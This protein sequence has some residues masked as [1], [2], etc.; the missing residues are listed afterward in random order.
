MT[1]PNLGVLARVVLGTLSRLASC[2]NI[3]QAWLFSA[4]AEGVTL[5]D[6]GP[7]IDESLREV[8]G[9]DRATLPYLTFD[10][11]QQVLRDTGEHLSKSVDSTADPR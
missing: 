2:A 7:A 4:K 8:T 5:D 9:E 10:R 6:A 1:A 3:D 11:Q